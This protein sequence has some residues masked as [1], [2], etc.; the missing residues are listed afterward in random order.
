MTSALRRTLVVAMTALTL[1]AVTGDVAS[2]GGRSAPRP[3]QT[4]V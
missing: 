2:A 1:V 4:H 3:L